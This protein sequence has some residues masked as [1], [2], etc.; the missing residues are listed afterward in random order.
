MTS[1]LAAP[2][3]IPTRIAYFKTD[4]TGGESSG[5]FLAPT[6]TFTTATGA[7]RANTQV[8][9]NTF[10]NAQ[11]AL[12]TGT[13][14]SNDS[15]YRDMGAAFQIYVGTS[16]VATLNKAQKLGAAANGQTE[17]VGGNQPT[18]NTGYLVTWSAEPASIPVNVT[19]TGY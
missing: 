19:R 10:A 2:S 5:Y 15:L 4:N 6:S 16:L 14:L 18:Y 3:Q 12:N 9:F 7:T 8:F 1:V 17:G 11:T 13:I